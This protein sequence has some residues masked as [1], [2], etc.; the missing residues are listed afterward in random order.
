MKNSLKKS[1]STHLFLVI[2][3]FI[4]VLSFNYIGNKKNTNYQIERFSN[5]EKIYGKKC[6]GN[7]LTS[8]FNIL[9]TRWDKISKKYKIPYSLAYGTLLGQVRHQSFIPYDLDID[10]HIGKYEVNKLLGLLKYPWC[11]YNNKIN[12]LEWKDNQI[13]LIINNWHNKPF[14]NRKRYN[15]QG[16]LVDKQIDSCSFNGLIARLIL[17]KNKV[18]FYHLD[19]FVYHKCENNNKKSSNLS[20]GNCLEYKGNYGSY[21]LSKY[22]SP[23]DT[24]KKCKLGNVKT[25]CLVN[26]NDYLRNIYGKNYIYPDHKYIEKEKRFQKI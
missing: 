9:L 19:I 11:C 7:S 5:I 8:E 22:G 21:I 26:A 6:P 18:Q 2:L 4:L 13:Y 23:L 17:K 14:K 15:C 24:T 25:R 10:I 20:L 3:F 1:F 12:G 16:E